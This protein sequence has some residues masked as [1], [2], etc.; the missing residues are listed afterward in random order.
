M[1]NI[2]EESDIWTYFQLLTE[3][4]ERDNQYNHETIIDSLF[5]ILIS[6][7]EEIKLQN[8]QSLKQAV[9]SIVFHQFTSLLN[10]NYTSQ[11]NAQFYADALAISYKHLNI[12]CKEVV[13]KTAKRVIDDF[14]I[15]Q[16][17]R[18]LINSEIKS[19][20]LAYAL[21]FEDPTNFTKFFKKRTGSTPKTFKNA[22]KK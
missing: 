15:L 20:E 2:A 21:G 14:I 10:E 13:H 3:E 12:I 7:L 4:Y 17:K 11:R 18:N 5:V 19:T 8:D 1:L 16:A 22:F 6:K 9:K